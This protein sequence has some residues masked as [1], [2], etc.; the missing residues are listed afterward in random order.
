MQE[1]VQATIADQSIVRTLLLNDTTVQHDDT[2]DPVERGDSVR[3]KDN[4][5]VSEA[6]DQ[7]GEHSSFGGYIQC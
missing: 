5:F 4:C 2:I 3:Y 6:L 1:S 7:I